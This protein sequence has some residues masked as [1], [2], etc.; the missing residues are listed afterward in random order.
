MRPAWQGCPR[1][2]ESHPADKPAKPPTS[3]AVAKLDVPP[4]RHSAA[5]VCT[6]TRPKCLKALQPGISG[7][8]L[9]NQGA[10]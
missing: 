3:A 5:L 8:A 4:N 7:A 9:S 2:G 6:E 10:L 1:E